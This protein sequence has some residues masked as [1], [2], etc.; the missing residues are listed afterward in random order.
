MIQQHINM[1]DDLDAQIPFGANDAETDAFI[2]EL[3]YYNKTSV[4]SRFH[5]NR[6]AVYVK[7]PK[8]VIWSV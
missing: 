6:P 5:W 1:L 8:A 7:T 2:D 4:T 3:V